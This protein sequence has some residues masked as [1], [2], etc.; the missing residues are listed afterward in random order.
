MKEKSITAIEA[1]ALRDKLSRDIS[2][3]W[4]IISTENVADK[5]YK[6]NYDMKL[7]LKKI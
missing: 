3:M 2:R 1:I 6:R 7:I 4:D 5:N